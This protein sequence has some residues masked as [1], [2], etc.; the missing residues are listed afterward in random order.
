MT[1]RKPAPLSEIAEAPLVDTQGSEIAAKTLWSQQPVLILLIR[2]PGCGES[3]ASSRNWEPELGFE[4]C[5]LWRSVQERVPDSA[6][7]GGSLAFGALEYLN[8]C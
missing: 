6:S 4:P 5:L 2:R 7:L 8:G 1:E 3:A